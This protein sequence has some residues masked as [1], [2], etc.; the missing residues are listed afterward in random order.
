MTK[1][2]TPEPDDLLEWVCLKVRQFVIFRALQWKDE[3]DGLKR[4]RVSYQLYA[5]RGKITKEL[6]L[7]VEADRLALAQ[8]AIARYMDGWMRGNNVML[9]A[10]PKSMIDGG[11]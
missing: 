10:F 3:A 2:P 4:V 1:A 9:E 6:F 8:M 7:D 5:N 11:I